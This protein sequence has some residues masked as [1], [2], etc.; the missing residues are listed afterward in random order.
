M[1]DVKINRRQFIGC[2]S[3]ITLNDWKKASEKL[4]L[5][6][7]RPDGGSSH[8]AVRTSDNIYDESLKSLVAT[9]YPG[10]CQQVNK[11]VFKLFLR[12]GINEDDL[13]RALGKLK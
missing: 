4:G 5:R 2:F 13:W 12:K 11:K 8:I 7:T 1:D 9:I 10:M 3:K 6:L